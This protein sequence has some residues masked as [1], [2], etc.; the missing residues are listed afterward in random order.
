MKYSL[1]IAALIGLLSY[2]QVLSV[3]ASEVFTPEQIEQT[4][5]A[6][7]D[8]D[9]DTNDQMARSEDD[10]DEEV[11]TFNQEQEQNRESEDDEGDDTLVYEANN[12]FGDEYNDGMEDHQ[13]QEE[14]EE[15]NDI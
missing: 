12:M 14:D 13:E 10:E 11:N 3:R 6:F 5:V 8:Q 4:L 1:P 15:Q 2:E 7:G 9:D